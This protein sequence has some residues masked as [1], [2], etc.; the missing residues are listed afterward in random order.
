MTHD[1]ES[2][3]PY[4][5]SGVR[6]RSSPR[7]SLPALAERG[8]AIHI[9]GGTKPARGDQGP[10][11]AHPRSLA[12]PGN[13]CERHAAVT[14]RAAPRRP[15]APPPRRPATE[16]ITPSAVRSCVAAASP[17]APGPTRAPRAPAR[18]AARAGIA[19]GRHGRPRRPTL[20]DTR[21]TRRRLVTGGRRQVAPCMDP[22][23]SASQG[24][25][26]PDSWPSAAAPVSSAAAPASSTG[27]PWAARDR[28][29]R[30]VRRSGHTPAG[31]PPPGD[32]LD[33]AI[34]GFARH[35]RRIHECSA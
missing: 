29:G 28:R 14:A 10:D 23:Q 12:C 8:S 17:T 18:A 5:G 34:A 6:S 7:P 3:C 24:C 15:A 9:S 26:K 35:H 4:R 22:G 2:M 20:R 32:A 21:R 13:V 1:D 31:S 27:H 16:P 30:P 33:A 25:L 11:R 19:S